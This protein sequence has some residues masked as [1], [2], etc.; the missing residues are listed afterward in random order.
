[1]RTALLAAALFALT[2]CNIMGPLAYYLRPPD[3][4]KAEYPLPP[5]ARLALLVDPAQPNYENPVFNGGLHDELVSYFRKY[6]STASITPPA[7]VMELRRSA[8][9]FSKWSV[10]RIGRE[11]NVDYVIYLHVVDFGMRDRPDDPIITPHVAMQMKL[12]AVDHPSTD[13][14]V[15]P[16]DPEGKFIEC[17]RQVREAGDYEGVDTEIKKL[18]SEAAYYVMMPFFNVNLEDHHQV[19]Q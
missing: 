14:R 8:V 4:Q 13:A 18:G 9:D 6:K 2:G 10:Q 17:A 11:L 3:I 1:M 16:D 15:W 12:I 19:T 5:R 7:E